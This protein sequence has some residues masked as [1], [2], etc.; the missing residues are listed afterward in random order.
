MIKNASNVKATPAVT[1]IYGQL[2]ITRLT[3][4]KAETG[5]Q[6][7]NAAQYHSFVNT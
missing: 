3:F 2:Y 6:A 1:S 5:I 4:P 7:A